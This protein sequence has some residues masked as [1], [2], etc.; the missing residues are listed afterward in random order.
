MFKAILTFAPV[1]IAALFESYPCNKILIPP[2]CPSIEKKKPP[3]LNLSGNDV[4]CSGE[5]WKE[6][7]TKPLL[8]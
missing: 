5:G 1:L 2:I 3:H 7:G 6:C 4:S 8:V